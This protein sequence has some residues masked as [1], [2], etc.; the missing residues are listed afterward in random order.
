MHHQFKQAHIV[1]WWGQNEFS[2]QTTSQSTTQSHGKSELFY[3]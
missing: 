2:T 1:G 3:I